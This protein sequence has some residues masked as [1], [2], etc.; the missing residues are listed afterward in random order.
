MNESVV[1]CEGCRWCRDQSWAPGR[2][3]IVCRSPK[4]EPG[5]RVLEIVPE[6]YTRAVRASGSLVR[7]AHCKEYYKEDNDEQNI[8]P[9][10]RGAAA[11][12]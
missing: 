7:A 6:G 3:A 10:L 4:L 12:D 9:Q 5:V 11:G 8:M 1:S 2:E